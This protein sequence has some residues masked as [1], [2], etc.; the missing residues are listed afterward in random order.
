MEKT[1][2]H[3]TNKSDREL[4]NKFDIKDF[5]KKFE[6][7]DLNKVK[8]PKQ[9]IQSELTQT[10]YQEQ[11]LRMPIDE[12]DIFILNKMNIL[13]HQKPIKTIIKDIQLLIVKIFNSI[14]N[15]NNPFSL[16]ISSLDN[17]FSITIFIIGIGILILILNNILY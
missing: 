15:G 3:T 7:N 11:P 12:D 2:T 16:I 4:G 5:N 10:S 17:H 1:S 8:S 13:P 9:K 14:S 6:E